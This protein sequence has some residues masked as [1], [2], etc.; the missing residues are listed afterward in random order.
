[1]RDTRVIH[2]PVRDTRVIHHPRRREGGIYHPRR[3][4]GGIYHPGIPPGYTPRLYTILPGT[5]RTL[6]IPATVPAPCPVQNDEA[7]GSRKEKPVG[8]K[9]G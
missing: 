8:G 9:E 5:P 3:R 1:V 6:S 4:E 2:H 7:L